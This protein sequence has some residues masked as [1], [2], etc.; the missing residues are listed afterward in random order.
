MRRRNGTS[1][2]IQ[3]LSERALLQTPRFVLTVVHAGDAASFEATIQACNAGEETQ[4]AQGSPADDTI[5]ETLRTWTEFGQRAMLWWKISSNTTGQCVGTAQFHDVAMPWGREFQYD[6]FVGLAEESVEEEDYCLHIWVLPQFRNQGIAAEAGEAIVEFLFGSVGIPFLRADLNAHAETS[7]AA[8]RVC[9][10]LGFHEVSPPETESPGGGAV[11][12][13]VR[14]Y[15]LSR[16]DFSL[17][18]GRPQVKTGG[19][20]ARSSA[21]AAKSALQKL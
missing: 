8:A 19:K 5:E 14:E 6:T 7:E 18:H 15:S 2:R 9:M 21:R 4:A 17:L 3:E 13:H 10:K 16:E 20:R 12:E 1:K 11:F